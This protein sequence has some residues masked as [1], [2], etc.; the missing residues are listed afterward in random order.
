[1]VLH[2]QVWTSSQ[3]SQ[4]INK[5]IWNTWLGSAPVSFYMF[6]F[7]FSDEQNEEFGYL[8]SSSISPSG[9]SILFWW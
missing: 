8:Q 3:R 7:S 6:S 1:M 9:Q 4:N 5:W 2:T